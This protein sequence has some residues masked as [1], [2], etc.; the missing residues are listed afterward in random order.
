VRV[1]SRTS[2]PK[3]AGSAGSEEFINASAPAPGRPDAASKSVLSNPESR[4]KR[5]R[6]AL[7]EEVVEQT[8]WWMYAIALLFGILAISFHLWRRHRERL[9]AETESAN[10]GLES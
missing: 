9:E 10:S 7:H 6:R 3:A 1:G 4:V 5:T 2:G 8:F